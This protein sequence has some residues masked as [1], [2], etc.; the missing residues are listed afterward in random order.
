MKKKYLKVLLVFVIIIAIFT[1]VFV[2]YKTNNNSV[3]EIKYNELKEPQEVSNIK[4]TNIDYKFENDMM[5]ISMKIFNNNDNDVKLSEFLVNI[6]DKDGNLIN[7][8]KPYIKDTIKSR[9]AI[10]TEFSLKGDLKN[11]YSMKI[12][13]PNLELI[14][15]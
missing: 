9:M 1:C 11:A 12:E 5:I 7:T 10:N 4:F 8:M 14:E 6:Y 3:E 13:L 15:K 2:I